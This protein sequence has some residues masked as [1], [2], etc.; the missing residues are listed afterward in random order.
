MCQS[1]HSKRDRDSPG[2]SLV[3]PPRLVFW[4]TTAGCNLACVHC[5]RLQVSGE[6][7]KDDLSTAAG[8]ALIDQLAAVGKPLLVLSGGEPLM[9]PDIFELARHAKARGLLIALATNGTLIDQALAHRIAE[10]GFDRVSVSLDGADAES[11]DQFRGLPG[12]FA[13]SIQALRD[14]RAAGVA[15][16]IN[17]TIARPNQHQLADVLELGRKM[18]VVAVHYFLLVPVGCGEQIAEDQML[19]MREVEDRLL[20]ICELEQG[21]TL[22]IKAT[23]APH[24]HRI[25]R[26]WAKAHG[27]AQ[28]ARSTPPK[29]RQGGLHSLTKGCLAGT[30][31]CFVSHAGLVFPCG[32]LPV[33]AGDVRVQSFG[34]IWRDSPV[35]ADLRDP[36]R[37]TGKC[38][39]CEFKKVC[40]GCRARAF[41]AYGNYLAEEPCCA[42]EPKS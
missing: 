27:R 14:L 20:E 10:V 39:R 36:D 35:F 17:C 40:A 38:G 26:Q 13:K 5:R 1:S 19:D 16:Q 24:Y 33:T 42:Y 31:V 2:S 28:P 32:Y 34:E 18:G 3:P 7:M 15:T 21:T 41:H 30:A 8:L 4:E 22:Q 29:G 9:R 11:H 37:L 23:C 6:L 25:I 12:A